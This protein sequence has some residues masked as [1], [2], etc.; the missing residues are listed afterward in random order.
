VT[1]KERMIWN[2]TTNARNSEWKWRVMNTPTRNRPAAMT[3][4]S[5]TAA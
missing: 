5:C 3:M 2:A 1:E 4:T